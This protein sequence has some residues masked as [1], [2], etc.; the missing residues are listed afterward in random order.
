MPNLLVEFALKY[1]ERGWAIIPVHSVTNGKCTCAKGYKCEAAGKHPRISAWQKNYSKDPK[2]ITQWFTNWPDSNIGIVTGKISGINVLDIDPPKGGTTSLQSLVNESKINLNTLFSQTGSGGNHFIY[3]TTQVC[4]RRINLLPGVDI[5]AEDSFIVAPPSRHRSGSNYEWKNNLDPISFSLNELINSVTPKH[6]SK[7][8]SAATQG[9]IPTGSRNETLFKMGCKMI[10]SGFPPMAIE[11]ALKEM[12]N[13]CSPPLDSNELSGIISSVSKY[14]VGSLPL[15]SKPN[16][17]DNAALHGLVGQFMELIMPETESD[18]CAILLQFLAA[19]GNVVGRKPFFLVEKTKHTSNIFIGL[20][21]DTSKGRK[22]TSWAYIRYIFEQIVPDL[23]KNN[24]LSG[25]STGEGL[26]ARVR[27][28]CVEHQK[29]KSGIKRIEIPG[30]TDKRLLVMEPELASVLKKMDR[31]G[32]NMSTVIREA[33]DSGVLNIATKDELIRT[34]QEADYANGFGNRF[35]WAS[36]ARS[37][38]LPMGGS[39]NND[40]LEALIIKLKKSFEFATNCDRINFND[41]AKQKWF[42]IYDW[43]SEGSPGLVGAITGRAEAQVIRLSL[44][45]ALLD[46]SPLIK[47]DHLEA[48]LAVWKY[49]EESCS[50]IFDKKSENKITEKITAELNK[51][52]SGLTRTSIRDLFSRNVP[53]EKIEGALKILAQNGAAYSKAIPTPGGGPS[54][55]IWFSSIQN[56]GEA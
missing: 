47:L 6:I 46:C 33:W 36:I 55:E 45:Y 21:G 40:D 48:A 18:P 35:L 19:F 23:Q 42:E 27:D 26:I 10:S 37:K 12:N 9:T 25:L 4:P 13:K 1:I 53:S 29:T 8:I 28:A 15:V 56:K 50:Y 38:K 20:V 39:L 31:T 49:C 16:R 3:S 43:L 54:T 32:N 2:T 24:I 17:L 51:S 14:E 7:H 34:L 30:V 41:E 22:G 52:L 11:A 44:I 5:I